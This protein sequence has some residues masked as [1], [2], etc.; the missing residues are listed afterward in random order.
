MPQKSYNKESKLFLLA[1]GKKNL[2]VTLKKGR[3]KATINKANYFYWYLEKKLNRDAQKGGN[4][5]ENTYQAGVE[6]R[7][8]IWRSKRLTIQLLLRL[9]EDEALKYFL[10]T[11]ELNLEN[12][13]GVLNGGDSNPGHRYKTSSSY[14]CANHQFV[15]MEDNKIF[16]YYYLH[17]ALQS[18]THVRFIFFFLIQN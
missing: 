14:H 10:Y 5:K 18:R 7:P 11:V 15:F 6:P 13:R 1:F 9:V 2:T 16:I 17:V 3:K 12:K 8:Q 4:K